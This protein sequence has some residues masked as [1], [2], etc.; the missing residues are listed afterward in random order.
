MRMRS[1]A[2]PGSSSATQ[3]THPSPNADN[4]IET[5]AGSG[6]YIGKVQFDAPGEWTIRFHIHEECDDLL[7][8]SPHGHAAFHLTLP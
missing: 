2:T 4:L 5:P 7:D 1:L 3:S 6:V 8:D